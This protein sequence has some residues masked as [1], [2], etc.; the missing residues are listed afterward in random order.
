MGAGEVLVTSIDQEG[1][2]RGFDVELIKAL[3]D[4]VNVPIIGSGGYGA[5][6]HLNQVVGAGADAAA[7]ADAL[8]YNRTSLRDLREAAE[9]FGFS[10]RKI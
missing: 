2:R 9:S 10:V 5:P 4:A 1:T 7:F 3:G 8:H 6:E